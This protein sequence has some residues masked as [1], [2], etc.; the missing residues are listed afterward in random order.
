MQKFSSYLLQNRVPVIWYETGYLMEYKIVYQRNIKVY[1]GVS[2][3][4]QFEVLNADQ[5]RVD[6]SD[7]T[8]KLYVTT[9][10]GKL[11]LE[12]ELDILNDGSS[13]LLKGIA[14]VKFEEDDFL[15][16][17]PQQLNY[18]LVHAQGNEEF[19]VFVNSYYGATGTIELLS[20][21]VPRPNPTVESDRWLLISDVYRGEAL[22]GG[23][24]VG[25]SNSSLH[26]MALYT[27]GFTGTVT[28]YATVE[29]SVTDFTV[30]TEI[31]EFELTNQTGIT[32]KNY[33]GLYSYFRVDYQLT[34]GTVDKVLLRN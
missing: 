27:T 33:Q 16:Y 34:A 28:V 22:E 14:Q 26:T 32:N 20:G 7:K 5:K 23:N 30:W 17:D 3:L 6:I 9:Q 10:E 24:S 15:D 12:R 1:K 13:T 2:N 31:D 21:I 8:L 29:N 18:A 11:V 25:G 4:V 19:P